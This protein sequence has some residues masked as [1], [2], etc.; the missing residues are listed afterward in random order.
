MDSLRPLDG[1]LPAVRSQADPEGEGVTNGI[2]LDDDGDGA[3]DVIDAPPL[4]ASEWL[5]SDGRGIGDFA[6]SDADG[7]GVENALDAFPRSPCEWKDFD[8]DR[9]GDNLDSDDDGDGVTDSKDFEPSSR[10]RLVAMAFQ[11]LDEGSYG[12]AGEFA[13]PLLLARKHLAI[14]AGYL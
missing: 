6:D 11:E 5:D 10:A 8:G 13:W 1:G 2:D 9:I 3:A 12:W 7:D 14:P 4:D